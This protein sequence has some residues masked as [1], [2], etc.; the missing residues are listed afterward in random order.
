MVGE[1]PAGEVRLNE[2]KDTP[3]ERAESAEHNLRWANWG[4]L[5]FALL[6][7]VCTAIMAISGVRLLIGLGSLATAGGIFPAVL[8]FHQDAI[9]IPMMALALVGAIANLYS[10]WRVR[11]LRARPAS[12]WRVQPASH[13]KIRSENVQVV[14]AVLTLILLVV[15]WIIHWRLHGI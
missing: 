7:S 2:T 13:G 9:R 6:Q 15:E 12:Q 10:V 11:S 1:W 14:L 4:S 5:L 8:T 3:I